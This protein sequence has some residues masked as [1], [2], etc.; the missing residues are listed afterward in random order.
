MHNFDEILIEDIVEANDVVAYLQSLLNDYQTVS[1]ADFYTI[2]G[3]RPDP[4]GVDNQWGWTDLSQTRVINT[5]R[6]YRLALPRPVPLTS[7]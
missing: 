2:V 1:V 7:Y 3:I 4:S 5:G 6:G